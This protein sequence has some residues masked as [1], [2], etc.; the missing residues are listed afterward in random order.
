MNIQEKVKEYLNAKVHKEILDWNRIIKLN[1]NFKIK[2][3]FTQDA[4]RIAK[5]LAKRIKHIGDYTG[6][7]IQ[8]MLYG[9][10]N[11]RKNKVVNT[12]LSQSDQKIL[13]IT[14]A[15]YIEDVR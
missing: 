15:A 3:D 12:S 8:Y 11:R 13:R 1:F 14:R 2:M 9:G 7:A 10:D 4:S 6:Q 5:M